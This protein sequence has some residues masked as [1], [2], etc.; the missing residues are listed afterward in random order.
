M[1]KKPNKP[2]ILLIG[3]GGRNIGLGHLVR[4]STLYDALYPFYDIRLL[5]NQE[6]MAMDFAK[7]HNIKFHSYKDYSGIVRFLRNRSRHDL[8]ITDMPR[9]SKGILKALQGYC[10]SLI[11]FD[12]LRQWV[13]KK[14]KGLIICPQEV[15]KNAEEKGRGHLIL[16]GVDYFPMRRIFARYRSLKVFKNSVHNILLCLGGATPI[17]NN[18]LLARL[19][20]THLDKGISIHAVLGYTPEKIMGSFSERIFFYRRLESMAGLIAKADLG[21]ISGG[22]IKFEFMCI[23]TPFCSLSLEDHQAELA[24]KFSRKG[25]GMYL[26]NVKDLARYPEDFYKKIDRFLS[27]NSLRKR[28]FLRTR[29]LVDGK[30]TR[31]MLALADNFIN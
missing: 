2:R 19:L 12:D 28:M 31:R 15:C 6:P 22:F 17:R 20:D 9:M 1:K 11:V 7:G 27:A 4:L 29:R 16:K 8:I 5:I 3:S 18:L 25:Y 24:K 26:G 10:A 30:G 14:I 21:I 13:D 23:G